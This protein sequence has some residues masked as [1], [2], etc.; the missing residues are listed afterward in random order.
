LSGGDLFQR[1]N[2]LLEDIGK[3]GAILFKRYEFSKGLSRMNPSFEVISILQ[4]FN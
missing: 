2:A 3:A 4:Y 1:S